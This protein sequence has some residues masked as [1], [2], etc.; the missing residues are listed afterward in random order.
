MFIILSMDSFID[1]TLNIREILESK[2]I[3][4]CGLYIQ[5]DTNKYVIDLNGGIM[6]GR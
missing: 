1:K 6:N 2:N 5:E 4:V 3:S